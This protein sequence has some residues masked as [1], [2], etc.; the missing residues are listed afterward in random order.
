MIKTAQGGLAT[1]QSRVMGTKAYIDQQAKADAIISSRGQYANNLGRA[2]TT[3]IGKAA[4]WITG[5]SDA[6]ASAAILKSMSKEQK[7]LEQIAKLI[8]QN[9]DAGKPA[10][11][12]PPA[13]PATP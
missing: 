12:P 1:E 6:K 5:P 13:P 11:T 9:T 3:R 4:K 7:S 2:P 8:Q 10:V